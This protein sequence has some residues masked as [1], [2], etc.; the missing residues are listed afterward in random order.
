MNNDPNKWSDFYHKEIEPNMARWVG[1]FVIYLLL[2]SV[3]Y[4]SLNFIF[5]INFVAVYLPYICYVLFGNVIPSFLLWY[6]AFRQYKSFARDEA[7]ILIAL[8]K[9]DSRADAELEKLYRKLEHLIATERFKTRVAISFVPKRLIPRN[10]REAHKLR[11][12]CR[13]RLIVWG[14]ADY[15]NHNSEPQTIFVPI[16]FSYSLHLAPDDAANIVS[17]FNRVL[18]N[19]KWI[20]SE[21]NNI[22]DREYL[23]N[24]LE[25]VSLYMLGAVMAFA[26]KIEEAFEILERVLN[27]YESKSSI[28]V[29]DE[30][31]IKNIRAL[32]GAIYS[33]EVSDLELWPN[34]KKVSQSIVMARELLASMLRNNF[35]IQA[36]SL[37]AQIMF[38]ERANL[39]S[40]K[41]KLKA[42]QKLAPNHPSVYLSLAYVY[43]YEGD[44]ASAWSWFSKVSR[45][46]SMHKIGNQIP[47]IIRWYE[48]AL[49]EDPTKLYLHFPLGLIYMDFLRDYKNA[50]E[51]LKI[52]LT[53]YEYDND[54][55]LRALIYET[56]KHLKKLKKIS[57]R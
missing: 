45:N 37:E 18:A 25:E 13:A 52:F 1:F 42:L 50:E 33:N 49:A 10:E 28:S 7:G 56:K 11:Q 17:G 47:S 54:P 21:A 4:I 44:Y 38:A 57:K 9:L 2:T 32:M 16:Y 34:S 30:I 43:F 15:G 24:N 8:T 5:G 14:N 22:I 6:F 20:I 26:K 36:L 48:E 29:D 35:T 27:M 55:N 53:S 12:R 41:S 23:A 46:G 31:S 19:R 51:S 3:E 39:N 40:I